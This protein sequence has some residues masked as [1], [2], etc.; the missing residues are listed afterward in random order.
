[1]RRAA[2]GTRVHVLEND[3]FTLGDTVVLGCTLWTDFELFG[4][5]RVAGA[6]ATQTMTDY[7][8]I[9]VSPAYRRLRSIDTAMHHRRSRAWL[10]SQ[11]EQHRGKSLVVVTHH[12]PSPRSLAPATAQD[13]T[14]AAYASDLDAVVERSDARVWIH[15]H[16]HTSSDYVLGHTRVLCNPRGYPDEANPHFISGLTIV[17]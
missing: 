10:E 3:A 8:K 12:A 7:Q 9:R 17:V 5:P 2:E 15:G 13:L 14:N 1:V 16:V 4:N 11:L 6:H